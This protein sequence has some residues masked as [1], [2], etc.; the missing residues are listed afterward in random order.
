MDQ[1]Q[2]TLLHDIEDSW[3]YRGRA[4]IA[5]GILE[6]LP[7]SSRALDFGAGFGG[8]CSVLQGLATEVYAFEPDASTSE[9]IYTRDYTGVYKTSQEALANSYDL[10]GLFDVLEHI[11][12]DVEFLK[13]LKKS[14]TSNGSIVLTVPAYS[15][16]WG[17]LDVAS[18]HH[19]RYTRTM[20][21]KTLT[22]AGY[23]IRYI[24]YWN[25][26]LF[27]IAALVRLLGS[28]GEQGLALRGVL[29]HLLVGLIHIERLL[30]RVCS[31][32]FGL[33]VVTLA[34][35]LKNNY[36]K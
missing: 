32:P 28:A 35:P 24:S 16:L 6:R 12:D 1:H 22:E 26:F 23:Q 34:V 13:D 9:S 14:L 3:W 19:R 30:M 18:H 33:S 4:D 20:L 8:M 15:W 36:E 7:K 17:P 27:P 21:R 29:N 10:I 11:E 2:F 5:R 31:L 25:M